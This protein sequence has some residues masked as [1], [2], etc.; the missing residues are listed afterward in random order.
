MKKDALNA[1][2]LLD[3]SGSMAARWDETL[4]ALNSY[5]SELKKQKTKAVISV[6]VFDAGAATSF[7]ILRDAVPLKA[8]KAIT[9]DEV[10]PRGMTPLYDAIARLVSVAEEA[11][12][13]RTTLIILTD[14]HENA[15]REITKD[16]AKKMLDACRKKGWQVDH[17]GAD[18]DAFSQSAGMGASVHN[19]ITMTGGNYG[20]TM[21]AAAMRG[22]AYAAT[23]D[24]VGWSDKDRKAAQGQ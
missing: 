7:D 13:K 22:T 1:Y 23:G 11:K 20:A 3:R 5:V 16:Q 2:I 6:A 17:I 24:A 10:Q 21:K 18:F 15:S 12:G 19:T 9:G 4:G 14:G 8:W